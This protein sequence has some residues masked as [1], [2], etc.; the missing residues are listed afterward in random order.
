[1]L[2]CAAVCCSV[3]QKV[4]LVTFFH[5]CVA[6]CCTIFLA[7][8]CSVLQ[9]IFLETSFPNELEPYCLSKKNVQFI[10]VKQTMYCNTR[11]KLFMV[12]S[13]LDSPHETV[14]CSVLQCVALCC[15]VVQCGAVCCSMLQCVAVCC[16]VLQY[17][18][19]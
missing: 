1:M 18:A 2:Q 14:C 11:N 5:K 13:F 19:V 4:S 12:P 10:F 15:S 9:N 8:C 6:V 16:S 7:V 17:V 3:L